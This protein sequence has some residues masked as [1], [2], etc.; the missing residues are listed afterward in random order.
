VAYIATAFREYSMKILP[1][2]LN[3]VIDLS[4]V[5]ILDE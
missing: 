4:N 2:P 1:T 5:M 3:N